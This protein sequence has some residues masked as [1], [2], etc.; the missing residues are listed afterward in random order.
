MFGIFF[1]ATSR[2]YVFVLD[3]VRTNLMPNMDSLYQRERNGRWV[4]S[5]T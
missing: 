2:A 5:V 4:P 3:R 1:L